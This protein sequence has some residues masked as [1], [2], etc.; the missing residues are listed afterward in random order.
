[1]KLVGNDHDGLGIV[2]SDIY[3]PERIPSLR[4]SDISRNQGHGVSLRSLGLQ[5]AECRIEDNVESGIHYNPSLGRQELREMVGWLSM[6]KA[7]KFINVPPP[8]PAAAAGGESGGKVVELV[9]DEP[10]YLRTVRVTPRGRQVEST[11]VIQTDQRNVIG[12]QVISPLQN[13]STESLLLLDYGDLSNEIWN[14]R[15]NLT[16]FPTVTSSYRVTVKYSSGSDARGGALILLTAFRRADLQV[17]RSRLLAGPVP[18]LTV[19]SSQLRRNGR[20]LSSLHYNVF[21]SGD[22]ERHYLRKAN[23]SLQ[24]IGCEISGSRGEAVLVHTPHREF[25]RHP[26]AEIKYVLNYTTLSENERAIV[27]TGRDLRDSNNLFHWTLQNVT[28]RSNRAGGFDVRLPY[29]WQ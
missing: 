16:S 4:N 20:G 11:L 14:L 7:D 15:T 1:M 28:V 23:E 2:Y 26:L 29:V 25:G 27:Q 21:L 9:P 18:K 6:L 5:L 22:G 24:L 8:P 17:Q 10:R 19:S 3:Y 12:M 13:A